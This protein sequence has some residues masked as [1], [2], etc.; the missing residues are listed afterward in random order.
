MDPARPTCWFIVP[1]TGKEREQNQADSVFRPY[2]ISKDGTEWKSTASF[3]RDDLLVL[4]KLA[5][6]VHTWTVEQ[7]VRTESQ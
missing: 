3:G 1:A 6:Q 7:E 2:G 4:S 5:D